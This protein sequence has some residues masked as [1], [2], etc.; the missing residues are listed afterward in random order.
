MARCSGA[1]EI[2]RR[3]GSRRAYEGTIQ[4]LWHHRPHDPIRLET[5]DV[6]ES[7]ARVRTSC[8]LP[9]GMTGTAIEL[10]GRP[11]EGPGGPTG[12]GDEVVL[13]R[14]LIGRTVTVAWSKAVRRDDGR[15]DHFEAG[16]RFF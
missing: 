4:L 12:D 14:L 6:S 10:I 2:D 8:G 16:L 11:L 7:G 15:I 13:E 9:E 5:V 1:S 3:G